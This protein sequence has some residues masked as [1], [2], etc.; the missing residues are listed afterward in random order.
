MSISPDPVDVAP[1]PVEAPPEHH[2]S[3]HHDL[4]ADLPVAVTRQRKT[5]R[6]DLEEAQLDDAEH[7][8][9]DDVIGRGHAVKRDPSS[10]TPSDLPSS[11]KTLA[12]PRPP[13]SAQRVIHPTPPASTSPTPVL[14]PRETENITPR[15][16][17]RRATR[18][19]RTPALK[20]KE[21]ENARVQGEEHTSSKDEQW[22]DGRDSVEY[23]YEYVPVVQRRKGRENM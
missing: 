23:A 6:A 3:H 14:M 22:E 17:E 2:T 18:A 10:I 21:K 4:P 5:D 13:P 20:G 8:E 7:N 19:E 16:P 1:A 11:P 9:H 15:A 12:L